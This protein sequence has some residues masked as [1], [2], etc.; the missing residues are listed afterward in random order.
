MGRTRVFAWICAVSIWLVTGAFLLSRTLDR[1]LNH[2]EHQF[3]VPSALLSR[4]CLL[5]YRDVPLFHLPNIVLAYAVLDRLTGEPILGPKLLSFAASWLVVGAILWTI[6][7]RFPGRFVAPLV[8]GLALVAFLV[9]DPVFLFTAGKT[10]NHEIPACLIVLAILFHVESA[11]R[12]SIALIA[13]SGAVCGLAIGTR[14]TFAPCL[15]PFLAVTF[16]F[17]FELGRRWRMAAVFTGIAAA[18]LAPSIYFLVTSPEPFLFGNL[19]F[20]RLRLLD[21]ENTRIKKTMVFSRKLRFFARQVA[22]PSWPLFIAFL[23]AIVAGIRRDPLRGNLDRLA[24]VLVT[25]VAA[26][27]VLGSFMPSRYQLQHFYALIP[28][29]VLGIA[30]ALG[31]TDASERSGTRVFLAVLALAL[32]A[33]VVTFRR[34]HSSPDR[35]F[36]SPRLIFDRAEWYSTRVDS[37]GAE[38]RSRI[39]SGRVLTLA[40]AWVIAGGLSVYPEFATGPFAWRS[41]PFIDPERRKRLQMVAPADLESFLAPQPPAAILTGVEDDELE[42]PLIAYAKAHDYLPVEI[43]RKRELWVPRGARSPGN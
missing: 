21:P 5:P 33:P 23:I 41:A 4:E 30:L 8:L 9:F 19:E 14:L 27:I 42:A 16:F 15:L 1:D 3:L 13:L 31:A 12:D 32:A 24:V 10:W 25:S 7:R 43:G 29:L 18:S 6:V 40:P 34:L 26:S 36:P 28:L 20:P 22:R 17:P 39:G 37:V 11:R 35:V 2:D 38:L